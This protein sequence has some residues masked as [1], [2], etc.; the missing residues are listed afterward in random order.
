MSRSSKARGGVSRY[1]ILMMPLSDLDEEGAK[2]E[3]CASF[4][5]KGH[6]APTTVRAVHVRGH[7]ANVVRWMVIG[8][9]NSTTTTS[10][11][12]STVSNA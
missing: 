10:Q 7:D 6:G 8:Q 12:N 5:K 4:V 1:L 9:W 3:G 2:A 11:K